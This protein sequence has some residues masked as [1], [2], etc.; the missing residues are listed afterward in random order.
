MKKKHNDIHFL[1]KGRFIIQTDSMS[2]R[3]LAYLGEEKEYK[4]S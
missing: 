3:E 2:T 4:E 1:D